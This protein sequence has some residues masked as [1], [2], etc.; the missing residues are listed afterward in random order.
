MFAKN[1]TDEGLISRIYKQ[2]IKLKKT[3]P[4]KKQEYVNKAFLQR[5]TD[6]QQAHGKMLIIAAY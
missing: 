2:L 3:N 6:G 4:I 5:H 1:A